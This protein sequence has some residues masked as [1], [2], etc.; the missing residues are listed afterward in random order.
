MNNGII[1]FFDITGAKPVPTPR[2]PYDE[3][4]NN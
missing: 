3:S 4:W 1:P 2:D